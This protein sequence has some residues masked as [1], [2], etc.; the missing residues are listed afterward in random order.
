MAGGGARRAISFPKSAT[1]CS[2]PSTATT[3]AIPMCSARCGARPTSRRKPT[4]TRR[5]TSASSSRARAT[6][7]ASTTARRKDVIT[8]P[9]QRRQEDRDRRRRHPHR[10]TR[11]TRSPSTRRPAS[12]SDR[13][14]PVADAQGAEDHDRSLG[15]ARPQGRRFAE[16]QRRHRED[17]LMGQ[18]AARVGDPTE[19]RHAARARARRPDGADRRQAGLAR[20]QRHPCLPARRRRQAACRR[21]RRQGQRNR[22]DRR[23]AGRA[24]RATWSSRPARPTRSRWASRRC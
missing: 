8:D 20:R 10:P 23:P 12:I 5:T 14:D 9:A 16:R 7:C 13:G 22:P 2:S 21:R 1:R 18:P 4:A 6:S 19:P 3:S 11:R 17:Q 24:R 15:L